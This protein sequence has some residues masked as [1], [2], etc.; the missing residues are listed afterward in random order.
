MCIRDSSEIA[1]VYH[2]VFVAIDEKGTE[3][4]AATAVV[5]NVSGSVGGGEQFE[6]IVDRTFHFVIH[7]VLTGAILFA[8]RVDDPNG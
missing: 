7:D 6:L 4:A 8:G 5:V 2:Q 1:D 3:A